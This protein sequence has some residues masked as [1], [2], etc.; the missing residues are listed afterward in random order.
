VRIA[1]RQGDELVLCTDD[2]F[3]AVLRLTP[4]PLPS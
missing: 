1:E 3:G 4:N 2:C